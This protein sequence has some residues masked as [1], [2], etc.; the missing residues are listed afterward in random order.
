MPLGG[1]LVLGGIAAVKGVSGL[2]QKRK[3]NQLAKANTRPTYTIPQEYLDNAALAKQMSQVGL[4][5]QQYNNTVNGINRNLAVGIG[6][7]GRSSNPTGSIASI[8]RGAND[9]QL[10]LDA[11]DAAARMNN[12]RL[13]MNQNAI[14]GN[15]RLAQQQWNQFGRYQ[16]NAAAARAL[17]AAGDQN[18]N[19]ALNTLGGTALQYMGAMQGDNNPPPI[20]TDLPAA[21][22]VQASQIPLTNYPI[23]RGLNNSYPY[24]FGTQWFNPIAG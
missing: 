8:V 13:F 23:Q 12:Q 9:A 22:S 24:N 5:Q 11:Q 20:R 15:Q 2:L 21:T 10:G 18:I 3:A 1:A 7:L 4:P 6:A 14:L 19:G 17:R 16:E